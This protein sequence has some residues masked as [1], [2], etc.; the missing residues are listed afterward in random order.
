MSSVVAV[1]KSIIG[2]VVAVSPEGAQRV[3][4]EGDRI[5]QGEQLVTGA[6]GAVTLDT[7]NGHL[8]DLGRD[9]QWSGAD[10]PHA[11]PAQAQ[12]SV[13]STEDLQQA[14]A[15]GLDPTQALAPTAAGP[16]AST[17]GSG[18]VGGGH[19]FVMLG[20]TAGRVA[21]NI[22]FPTANDGQAFARQQQEQGNNGQGQR[23][24]NHDPRG[25]DA[26]IRTDEDTP[27]S[28][29]LRA[30]DP[31][32]NPLRF[33]LADAPRNGT[34][35]V[36]P[37]GSYT[38][39]PGQN[40]NGSDRFTVIVN[41]GQGGRDT[42]TVNVGVNPVN[43][44][45]VAANDGPVAVTE[46]TPA[47][48][49]V[50]S[51][52]H[53]VDGDALAVTG[54]TFGGNSYAAGQT[55][56]ING[57]GSLVINANG[58]FTFT[59]AQNYNG[60]VPSATYTVS[61][62]RL[63]DSAQLS[64]GNVSPVNDAPV[65]ADQS[66]TTAEDTP[67]S[68]R[69]VATDVDHD[70]LSYTLKPGSEP[71]HGSLVLNPATG[72]YTYTPAKDYNGTDSFIVVVS[73]GHGGSVESVV[74]LNVT[75]VND[76]PE[77][78][79]QSRA[80]PEDT[81]VSG[82]IVAT[83]VDHDTLS[84]TLK[85][86][87]EPTHGTLVLNPATGEYTYTPAKDY[88]GA[89]SFTV[90]VSDGHGG[91]VESVVTLNVTPV[92][93]API[94]AND[95][96]IAVTE[97]TPATGNVLTNDHDVDGDALTVTGFSFGGNSYAAGQTATINGVGSLVI[98]GDGSFTFTPAQDYNG[99]VPT[100]T[101]TVSDGQLTATADLSFANVTPVDDASVLTPDTKTVA[102]DTPAIG[103]VLSND[104]DVD[105]VLSVA[106]FSI[107]GV[108]G[109][110]TAG[111]S[112]NINGVGSLVIN[113][114]GT[115]TFT[116]VK[117]WNGSVP[118]ITYTTNTGSSS[119][120]NITVTP[121]NDAPV[122]VNDGPVAVT[123]D[124]P[125]T[126][127][128]LNNDSDVDGDALTVT[129]FSFGGNSY[130]AGQ[131]A[132]INGVGSLVINGDGSFTFTPAQDYN[133]P[134]PTATYTVSDGQLTATA[135]LSFANVTP[136]DDASVLTPDTKTV[137]E[138]TPAIGN[139]LSNDHD[140]D[141]VL[142]VASFSINGVQGSFTAGQSAN[143][144]GVGSLVIN[145]DGTYTFTPVKDWNGS[146][147]EITY[148]TNTGS[149][150]TLNITVTPV[151][152]APVAVND[153]PVA[154]TEDTPATGNV[155]NNDSDVD[156]DA[157]TVTG[158]SFG[159]NNYAAGQTATI[160]G[161]GSLVINGDGSFT[162]TPAQDYNGPVP[163][164]T[165][166]VS[167]GQLT[168]TA[169][170]SFA[171]VTPVDDASVLT[172]D[173]KTVAEDTPA[174]GNVLSNDHDVD[175]VLSVASFSINGVQ[176][177]FTA[178][179]SANI[180][181]VGSLVINSDGT[182]TFTPV[183]DW[184]GSV[185]EITYTTNTGSSSTL[186]ITVTPVNDA[187]VAVNDGPVAVTEDTPATGN[188]LNNDSDVDGD[189]LTVTGFSFG[190]NNYAAGQTATINGVGSLVI[191]GD[192]SFT[193]TPAQDYNGPVPT[194][195]Y[196]VSDGQLTA[197]ADLSFA[198]VTPVDDPSV[199]TPDTKTVAEDTP[200]TG[201]VLSN[202]HDVDNV[203]SVASFSINGVQGSFTAGQT[204]TING[205]G[206]LVINAD[207]TYT[208]TPVKDW[209]GSVPEITYT[210]NTGSS[211]TLNITV[212]PVNDAPVAQNDGPVSVTED[213]P[214]TGNVLGNDSDVD[215][216]ALTVTG[217]SFGGHD[218]AAGQTATINGVGSLVINGDGSFT[219][220]PAHN[221]NGPVPS[222][223]YTVSDGQLTANA[224]LSFADV[225]SVND[226]PIAANDG[227]VAVTE[228]TPAT[229]NVLTND[230][231]VDGDALTVTGFSFGGNSYAAGQTAT[232]NG[233]GS[234]VINGDGS[235]NFTP[236]QDYN[237]PVPTAT[238]TVSDGQLTATADL[239][240]ANVT[241]VDDASV[242]TP[243]TKTVA[244]D[245]P[246]IGNVLSND[247]DVD[248]VLS[249]ASFSING[250]QGSFTAGQSANINGVGSLVINSDGTYTFTPVKDWNGSVPEIT[251]TTNTG[252]SST[253]NITVTPVNDAPVAVNDGPVA[254]TEDTPA[255]GN[256]LNNDSDVDGDAL[257]VTGFSF[258]GNNY[259]A[260]QTATI[261]G[262]GSLVING[263]GSFTF[264]PAQDYNGPVPTAT[265]TVSDGQLT[266]TADLSFADVTPVN[267]APIA[268]NDG[269]VAVTEDTPATGNVLNNDSDPEGDALAVTGFSFGGSDYAAGQTATING[270]GSLVINGDGSFT[271]TPAHNYNG[272]VPSATYTVSDGQLTDTAQLNFADVTPVNDAPIAVNDGPVA[273]TEDT[274]TTGNVLNNDSDPEGDALTVT[275]FSFGGS[276]Y[277]AGQTATINGVGS[278][279][280]NGDGSF[281][282]TPAHNY[283]GP[284]PSA[285]YTV[286][287]GQLTDTAQL[288]FA[289]VT[290]VNDAPVAAND[291]PIAVTEDTPATGNV[292]TNDHDVDGDALTVTGFSFGGNNYAAGQTA[293][294]NGVGSLVINGDGSFTFTPAQDYNGPVPSATYTVSDGQLTDTAQLNFA[295]VTPV[296]DAP[297]AVNDGPVA[298][299]EDT[300][301]TGN[302]L[303]N[304]HDVDGDAL[305]VTGFSFGGNSYAA[306][307]TATINGVGSLVINGDG[308]F[309]FTPAQD[310][311]GPVP[312][313]TYTVSDGQLTATADLS[314]ANVT[315]VDDPSVL[316]PD[317]KTV[318]EDTPATGNVLS[319]DHD[320]DNVLSVAGFSIN[321]VQG[322]FTAG[323][324]AN[325]NGVGSLVINSDGT[326][327]FTPVKDWNGSVP[328]ITYTTNTGSS[329]TLNITVTPVNDAPVANP[330]SATVYEDNAVTIDVLHNDTDVD[331]DPLTVTGANASNG[332]VAI[333]SD[334]TV[335]YTPKANFSGTDTITYTISDGHGGTSTSKVDVTIIA[336]ADKPSLSLDSSSGH[337]P[338][339]GLT[340][341]SW[342]GLALGTNGS[343][344]APSTLQS[345]I[346]G[347]GTPN[348]SSSTNSVNNASVSA[349][350]ANKVSGLIFLEAGHTY[351]F[352]GTGDDSVRL[353]V[354]GTNVA[355]ATWGGTSGKFSGT[356]TPT[357]SGYYTLALYQ[358]NQSG[359]GNFNLTFS[360]NG[361]APQTLGT[362]NALVYHNTGELTGAGERLSDLVG[363]NGQGHYT[364]FGANEGNEDTSIPLSKINAALVDT[365]GSES[366][367]IS[368][369]GIPN[370]ATLSDGI[371][372]F[373]ADANHG[374]VDVTGW[375]LSTLTFTPPANA[376][377]TITLQVSATA[378]E[379]SNHDQATT[380]LPL[381]IHVHAVNDAPSGA[382]NTITLNEDGSRSFSAADFGFTD[383]DQGDSL[384]AVRIDG[385]PTAGSLTLNGVAV[386]AGQVIA[387]SQLGGL[388]F[389]PAANAAG[390]HYA[391]F[392]FS[393]KDG[394]G[395]FDPTPNT[396]TLNV[397]PVNDAP[398]SAD[399]TASIYIG[400]TY[401]FGLKDFAFSDTA[402]SANGQSHSLQAVIIKSLPD[403]GALWLNGSKVVTG[404]AIDPSAIASGKLTFVPDALGSNAHF[405]F[406]V[407]D[408]GGTTNGG[409]DTS[410]THGFD[411]HVGQVQI[412]GST[413]NGDNNLV[414][415]PGDDVILGDVGGTLT[416]TQP[417]TNYNIALIVDTSG[418]MGYNLAGVSGAAY[419]DSRM[420][421]VKD[422]LINLANQLKGHDG[423]INIALIGFDSTASLKV[424]VND[425]TAANIN[426][427]TD[428]IGNSQYQ[429]LQAG[430]GTNYQAA[431]GQ[432]VIWFNDHKNGSEN[433]TLFL[434]DGDP[435]ES[436]G[437]GNL[438]QNTTQAFASLSE[439]SQV[440]A[441][442]IGTN[443]NEA[444]LKYFD[445]T[446][447]T[448][449]GSVT[450][451]KGAT[452]FDFEGSTSLP[453]G[454]KSTTDGNGSVSISGGKLQL[455]DTHVKSGASTAISSNLT[456]AA[457]KTSTFSF[458]FSKSMSKGDQFTWT[459]E[460]QRADGG[461]DQ[462]EQHA[463]AFNTSGSNFTTNTVGEG[464]YR[465]DFELN[466][467]TSKGNGDNATVTIDNITR[468]DLVT[469]PVGQV[470]IVK[471]ASDLTAALHGG[472]SS[473]DL[474]PSGNDTIHAGS[475]DDIVFG[476]SINTDNLPWGVNGNPVKPAELP[477]GSGVSALSAFLELKNGHV[478]TSEEMYSFIKENHALFNVDG[479]TRGGS[480]NL[481]G[482]EGNDILYGQGG[483][484]FLFGEGGNDI[485]FGGTG[486]DQLTG[487]KGNDILTGGAGADT[488]IWKAGDIGND[489]ITDFKAGE[490]DRID[491]SD[492]LPDAAHNDILSYLKVDTATSTLQV[493]TTGQVNSGA[494]VTIKLSG[495][496]LSTYGSNPTDIV[497]QLVAGSDPVV[498]TEHH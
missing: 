348:S 210:T 70:T 480:D 310:Y 211:S 262:V 193:F 7:G 207:G 224:Q 196:T 361:S 234:L 59:P 227:P 340:L 228:D 38:Y 282:F 395:A 138:D 89:D 362:G 487:G 281:T 334:G 161:V 284:V 5:Y 498:K 220:T 63:T 198:D 422:A 277:A 259:A 188:V 177:S 66:R 446:N 329:S 400:K 359:P 379:A 97:D 298:V 403:S 253:L 128:V 197:T 293:T 299:T 406:A 483:N 237:G 148:T 236:A 109:S 279:V 389:T 418:S 254:V 278:L 22:G 388:V 152:D 354:G 39:T 376:N 324:S 10:L 413:P 150:S 436:S 441:I 485:L 139:V 374:S 338:A 31:D 113:S 433:L 37:N 178:G 450:Y 105:N 353:V 252:S 160:N 19:S 401:T 283:N 249:V 218:Y 424:S 453:S 132:T 179:Q 482:G 475:G 344:A 289:D 243:D 335:T 155:L 407:Q 185:P 484:D 225:A 106:S 358:H 17:G 411:I 462:V 67:V 159:G 251:Y 50:L 445:N 29:Q 84:Y 276:D 137:A 394:A 364:V 246:A 168:A 12:L 195:T 457:G 349:G 13:P 173:T 142:S 434:T 102:E 175:N 94:A 73:D 221:Y 493:S 143:I 104:H 118:E 363:S 240:F 440:R 412:P 256:V 474:A 460:K 182:Y 117:D 366:L 385:L 437:N 486:D 435:T 149:S 304:D 55:A 164:A 99:P 199:L 151:N 266:A 4:V 154:V 375:N 74:K 145:S 397:T 58:S 258:G 83:D 431:F 232:I 405:D 34:V 402:D 170:L 430:G 370:G 247:H 140:V 41:D 124:T 209:N 488:F 47:T 494:D 495:V 85:P 311:N 328:E 426:L 40:F 183:K 380:T 136:V 165:Y 95:G 111:Q 100:A 202:D 456:V 191:N 416:V 206:S 81:P 399:A 187:P 98:N 233:V 459:L 318:A 409:V 365:D 326:Y 57:V 244:E 226:A 223:T 461:W 16:A 261:N 332:T 429:G 101:Y 174:I 492:L 466:D 163:T 294:I 230:H 248:N 267:D 146:V 439:L 65:T 33:D 285:T 250:V 176:G 263:D 189:A 357:E 408:S 271:F 169:D 90:V 301:A 56:T 496:D 121:V 219:F 314:F 286:S 265:Y 273:V 131:T 398:L 386:I 158:F 468:I 458:D 323:Q 472:S 351:T 302:V 144:N 192:G 319:N 231:D 86:G 442:G 80:T 64:F 387:A 35:V 321:G 110:F 476:D 32:G 171:N 53:D 162:F 288:N 215:G 452:L 27:V 497:K 313:A 336:V 28:G 180:N 15:A 469:A 69:I 369:G 43:D 30:N 9:S 216:D 71:T 54:F 423:V 463:I 44:A 447:V 96:P 24:P 60:P 125:A 371:H 204:A 268:V 126:G 427:L 134:V 342:T 392:T 130:A 201:N 68:G 455:M 141:N 297:I 291:G 473:S 114:D 200:A 26:S 167:D 425:L 383:V 367:S 454:W 360:D 23:A 208:F 120:L 147:P 229:G 88:N 238:Y 308:S 52:D 296:N 471:Q 42:I 312:T 194:A 78:A 214:A 14:I 3:L 414:G 2:Q 213:T 21:P 107:N 62:G 315:P 235:F 489:I 432:A 316:T 156:G 443:V 87:S 205:A 122:A 157:L 133:G 280:I 381:D 322:S 451:Y 72:E 153:G 345:V 119:T 382:D 478:A 48:G 115:Y 181:G 317:T 341:E 51:N 8:V 347:A 18:A 103:N 82:Q 92:N 417:G 112:A 415:G 274:P 135:D 93:D 306:G 108:Q 36:N 372:S 325:I 11:A 212:T 20:E 356:F 275:G 393:V 378:T 166:T 410:A 352:A 491:I 384:S 343:G 129:G 75:P 290:P 373:T 355:E 239:S 305:T 420:K 186:N 257:T 91:S 421:L 464:T 287:D 320:V 438:M 79:D 270:V 396:I 272:P 49:N 264:T 448:G 368:I 303:N 470:D 350:T 1:V 330:D 217:F 377:G 241:P 123:E 260:G 481:Y 428:A 346:D 467:Y 331:G 76:A 295:D 479:D 222:A 307:Q 339:T 391:D 333:N 404:Q 292:L 6:A 300:P 465:L 337:P 61:D 390:S 190:G 269:P 309:T 255:T 116:P 172:P 46:D 327:T 25:Q 127:N 45:P 490:G 444:T 419:T 242:L 245:T 477:A 184:N 203:L 77:T 449:A